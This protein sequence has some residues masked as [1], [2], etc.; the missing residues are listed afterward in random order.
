MAYNPSHYNV[1]GRPQ[2]GARRCTCTPLEFALQNFYSHFY[3]FVKF[4]VWHYSCRE[5][6]IGLISFLQREIQQQVCLFHKFFPQ[7]RYTLYLLNTIDKPLG[8]H[9]PAKDPAGAHG[10]MSKL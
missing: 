1:Q 8:L 4:S 10:T 6:V 3:S 9:P 5:S 2:A 7:D